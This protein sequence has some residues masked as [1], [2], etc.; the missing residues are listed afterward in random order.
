MSLTIRP[1][2]RTD[3]AQILAFITELA[4]YERARHEV[5][6]S[7][8]DI[9]RS[10][11]DEGST[12]HSL[13]CERD[14]QAIGFA[15]YFYS[16]STWLGRNGIYLEDLYVT[17]EQ[18][19]DGAGRTLLRHIAREAVENGCGRLEWS[20][21]DWNEPAIGFYQSLGAEAQAEWVKYRLDGKKL[22]A[23][24]QG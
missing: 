21:L 14:G 23:F 5:I 19:G 20:V 10:L 18:R 8:A 15:V 11:F 6:A 4:D 24:A 9:E 2:V 22:L 1:A 3:A 13:I 12:V 16:Y 7:V 17:P